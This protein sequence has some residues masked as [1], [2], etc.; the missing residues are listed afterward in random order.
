MRICL[1]SHEFPPFPGGGIATYTEAAALALARRGHEVHLVT[2]RA[3]FGS[4]DPAHAAPLWQDGNLTVH[5]LELFDEQRQIPRHLRFLDI[6]IRQYPEWWTLWA[7]DPSNQ[8]ALQIAAYV[9]RLHRDLGLDVI[10]VPE[11]YAEAF[12]IIRRRQ[13][14][15]SEDFPPVCVIAHT[16]SRELLGVSRLTNE[17]G[18]EWQRRMMWREDYCIQNADALQ[19]PSQSLLARYERRFGQ[20]L[21]QHREVIRYYLHVPGEP[22]PVPPAHRA[23]IGPAGSYVVCVGR[24]EPRKGTDVA[25]R[26]FALLAAKRP[27]LRLVLLG[28]E[29]WRDGESF[30]ETFIEPLPAEVRDRI[31]RLG[32]VPREEVL[33]IV[34]ESAA[35]LH[36]APW[37]NY[38]SA[39]LE[40][41]AVGA[42]CIVTDDGGHAEM[43]EDGR[44][45]LH[46]PV[47]DPAA[48]AAAIDR[49]LDDD[50][51]RNAIREEA[52][53]RVH[54]I[55]DA[56]TITSQKLALFERMVDDGATAAQSTLAPPPYLVS[57]FRCPPLPGSGLAVIDVGDANEDSVRTTFRSVA[58]ELGD[59]SGWSVA[60]LAAAK[61]QLELPAGW[62]RHHHLETPPW[63]DVPLDATVVYVKAGV[64]F[65]R[66]RLADLV[67]A[68]VARPDAHGCF[69]WLRPAN[70]HRFPFAP[71]QGARDLAAR[72]ALVQPVFAVAN[73][74][75]RPLDNLAGLTWAEARIAALMV[76]VAERAQLVFVHTGSI[77]GDYYGELPT[78]TE[79]VQDRVAGLLEASG[80]LHGPV[81]SLLSVATDRLITGGNGQAQHV[82]TGT[83]IDPAELAELRNIREQ[84]LALKRMP[85][86]RALRSLRL[87]DVARKVIPRSSKFLGSGKPPGS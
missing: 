72:G 20:A 86:I 31:V 67:H 12:Y 35:F 58:E 77:C 32:N 42:A 25:V 39:V 34:R 48:L 17:L 24:T 53:R 7:H 16:S 2:N 30:H 70:A 5:R 40:A 68:V 28:R 23:K 33:S 74:H 82:A 3:R 84:H 10:E 59:S 61:D 9:Q 75:L 55:S 41:M 36:P 62:T 26:A 64:R 13:C 37:D 54:R 78:V 11:Y 6:D 60:V 45:G 81:T 56:D 71:D 50:P 63:C 46:V 85:V 44:S 19:S 47:D 18:R 83:S 52:P 73:R 38:P 14:G 51:L 57:G 15:H 49:L 29:A 22:A 27:D 66:G 1:I 4:A 87:F 80:L 69:P 43:I 21:P 76:A 65:D 8:A 79:Q